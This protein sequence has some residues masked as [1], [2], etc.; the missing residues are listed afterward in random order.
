LQQGEFRQ[1]LD[2][3]RRGHELASKDPRLAKPSAD[4]VRRCERL[5]ELEEKLPGFLDRKATPAS[6]AER[7]ELAGLCSLKHLDRAA[8]RFY[9]DAFAAQPKLAEGLNSHR[10][11]AA[12]AAALAGCG[13]GKDAAALDE[14]ARGGLRRQALDWLR[15]D[16][17]AWGRE[18]DKAP[19]MAGPAAGGVLQHWLEDPDLAGV[20]DPDALAKLPEPERQPWRQLWTE[21]ADLLKRVVDQANGL[22]MQGERQF[23]AKQ[24]AEAE[25]SLRQALSLLGNIGANPAAAP[26]Y[27][28]DLA[29]TYQD[30]G[31]TLRRLGRPQPAQEAYRAALAVL[32]GLTV[33][34]P[35][36]RTYRDRYV[37]AA[38]ELAEFLESDS[39]AAEAQVVYR[40]ELETLEK[41]TTADPK[42]VE[43]QE[44]IGRL[45]IQLGQWDMAILV[46]TQALAIQPERWELWSGRGRAR[47]ELRQWDE[48]I[49]DY[50]RAIELAPDVHTNWFHRGLAYMRQG[51]WDGLVADYT[52]LLE[53]YPD[54]F[55]A[56]HDRAVGYAQLHQPEQAVA[57]L[58]QAFS[59]GYKDLEAVKKD[60]RFAPLRDR[61]D[62]QKLLA[63]LEEKKK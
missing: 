12:C 8:A 58:R 1:A 15:A 40:E 33:R 30:L 28:E 2:E 13:R 22:R 54:D 36:M 46:Y 35:D 27:R 50:T 20:R 6:A 52:K 3:L 43:D 59:K 38:R 17:E 37:Q 32:E 19:D 7:I 4:S 25:K 24:D 49:A 60:D 61:E 41:L 44:E 39:R 34:L 11:N 53:K 10:Y 29:K 57:D 21:V 63:E 47:L 42:S 31:A 55:N 51:K 5:L 23:E 56:L 14:K 48:C 26:A 9:E 62:F 18:L 45:Y 16:L